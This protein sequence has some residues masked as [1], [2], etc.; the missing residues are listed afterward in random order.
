MDTALTEAVLS[1]EGDTIASRKGLSEKQKET[2]VYNFE[3]KLVIL[4]PNSQNVGFFSQ[5]LA[6][7]AHKAGW[8]VSLP[9]NCDHLSLHK[10]P[11]VV[12]ERAVKPLEV[13]RA[14]VVTVLHEE[15]TM[16]QV[17]ATHCTQT[18]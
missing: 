11:T 13:Q 10:F 18:T 15:A 2:E 12:A 17:T 16:S 1:A 9:Q 7:G 6:K 3:K 14:E 4:P 5:L 8:V